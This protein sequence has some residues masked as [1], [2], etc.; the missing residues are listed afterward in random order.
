MA[1]QELARS[2]RA[3]VDLSE[4]L[5]RSESA[6]IDLQVQSTLWLPNQPSFPSLLPNPFDSPPLYLPLPGLPS[7]V[8]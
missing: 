5:D 7:L 8:C 6:R 1:D 3:L 2:D 4:E